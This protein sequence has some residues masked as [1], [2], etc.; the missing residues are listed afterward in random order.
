MINYT[1]E[2]MIMAIE[3]G[4]DLGTSNTIIYAKD[5]I[6]LNE[7]SVVAIN[8]NDGS[9]VA[10]G[11]EAKE[12][13]GRTHKSLCAV[14]PVKEGV[15]ANFDTTVG[16]LKSFIKKA[17]KNSFFRPKVVMGIPACVTEVEKR[18]VRDAGVAAG[19]KEV[20]LIEEPMAAAIGSGIEVSR[21]IGSMIVDIG[22]GLTEIAVISLGGIVVS[23]SV[24]VAGN[25][26]DSD[27]I[28]Y[29]KKKYNLSLGAIT[30]EEVKIEIGS[31]CPM[32]D[33][34]TM[35]VHGRDSVS[36]LPRN[37]H[38][39]SSEVREALSESLEI[40]IDGIKSVL[41]K[42]PPE[43]AADIYETGIVLAGGGATLRGLGKLINKNIDIPVYIAEE[44]M[45]CVA[46]GTG[47]AAANISEM[48][49]IFLGE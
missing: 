2:L 8:E 37:V 5:A 23:N 47:R 35:E 40:I 30:A 6:V 29:M 34:L 27:I 13:L 15:I 26:F 25:S 24:K 31:A 33:E 20:L 3:L 41:E 14:C 1:K 17:T 44:P 43:L 16:M 32:K 36:G 4:I 46:V 21:P 49:N 19:A 10:V 7:P 42:T 39:S 48:K 12:M 38:L 11:T 28:A 22:G 18:A 9:V 45:N